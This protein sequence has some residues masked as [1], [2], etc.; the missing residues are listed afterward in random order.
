MKH[1]YVTLLS[2]TEDEKKNFCGWRNKE[3]YGANPTILSYN[4]SAVKIYNVLSSLERFENKNVLW[5]CWY[6]KKFT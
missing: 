4:A 1:G 5:L 3:T 6:I 2:M